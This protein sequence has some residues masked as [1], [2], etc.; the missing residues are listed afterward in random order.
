MAPAAA[1][2]ARRL[3]WSKHA[4][5]GS[6]VVP[7]VHMIVTMSA[8]PHSAWTAA[9]AWRAA[10]PPAGSRQMP[11]SS[12]RAS[13]GVPAGTSG[14][15]SDVSRTTRAGEHCPTMASTSRRP[16]LVFSPVVIAP[17]LAAAA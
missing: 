10:A 16:I 9:S 2:I 12:D 15:G 13:T 7:L 1:E 17:A 3:A 5:F 6:P 8:G 14:I 4:P 11:A